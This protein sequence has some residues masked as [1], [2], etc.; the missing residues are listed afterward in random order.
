MTGAADGKVVQNP[1]LRQQRGTCIQQFI[2]D[3]D[4]GNPRILG[5]QKYKLDRPFTQALAE[6]PNEWGLLAN[7][8]VNDDSF[9]VV[10]E[11]ARGLLRRQSVVHRTTLAIIFHRDATILRL[12]QPSP[13][14]P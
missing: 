7:A 6:L 3:L 11:R 5:R 4:V 9:D 13:A 8:F 12:W 1:I 14:E 10:H 2:E